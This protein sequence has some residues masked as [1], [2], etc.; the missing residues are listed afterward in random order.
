MSHSPA[1]IGFLSMVNAGWPGVDAV[2]GTIDQQSSVVPADA[3]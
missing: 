1:R 2:V 3:P